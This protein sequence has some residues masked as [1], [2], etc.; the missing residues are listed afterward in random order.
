M[1]QLCRHFRRC[2]P[3]VGRRSGCGITWG[4]NPTYS[5]CSPN[6]TLQMKADG[7]LDSGEAQGLGQYAYGGGGAT[8]PD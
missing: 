1:T 4:M 3:L 7:L 8:G 2:V 6:I 5:T